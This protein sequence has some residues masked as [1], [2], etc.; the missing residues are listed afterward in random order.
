[1]SFLNKLSIPQRLTLSF[2]TVIFVGSVL[3]SMPIFHVTNVQTSYLEHLFTSVSMVCVTGLTLI[4]VG[5]TYNTWGQT[6]CIVLMQLGGLGL[7]TVLAAST[8]YLRKKLSLKDQYTLQ[9]SFSHEDNQD[10]RELL[11][12]IYKFT[13]IVEGLG[14]CLL[15]FFYIPKVGVFKGIFNSIFTAVS[16]FCNAGFDNMGANSLQNY[17]TNWLLNLT[18]GFLIIIGGIGFIVWFE[19]LSKTKSYLKEEPRHFMLHFRRLSVHSKVVLKATALVLL[20]AT[21]TTWLTESANPNTLLRYNR[22]EQGLISLFQSITMRTAGFSSLDY[23]LTR[24]VTNLIYMVQMF[25][26]GAPGGT[27]GGIKI[28]TVVILLFIIKAELKGEMGISVEKRTLKPSIIRQTIVVVGF[29]FS[30]HLLGYFLLLL[31]NPTLDPF[32]LLFETTSALATVGVTMNLTSQ[33]SLSGKIIIMLLMFIGRVG[34]STVL[35]SLAI[36]TRKEIKFASANL[37]IG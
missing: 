18:I 37:Y 3:L 30:I 1:M 15:S 28:T 24:P 11:G 22:F 4:S 5:D 12:S 21:A 2:L 16:A 32:A 6:I 25:I 33:L 23:T 34:P 14:A 9:M 8:F 19:I 7:I 31:T 20:L 36:K 26:G 13:F 27:A 17:P 10:L 35:L 29:F